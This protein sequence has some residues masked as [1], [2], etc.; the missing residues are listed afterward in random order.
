LG[1]RKKKKEKGDR[2][3]WKLGT[4]FGRTGAGRT[5]TAV[6]VGRR[7]PEPAER[8][9][10]GVKTL[11]G[12]EYCREME[13]HRGPISDA[14][15]GGRQGILNWEGMGIAQS[16]KRSERQKGVQEHIFLTNEEEGKVFREGLTRSRRASSCEVKNPD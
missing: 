1:A 10:S 6:L 16:F 14:H 7:L 8:L 12:L 5:F 4:K 3:C 13:N 2:L 9:D 15:R 11:G